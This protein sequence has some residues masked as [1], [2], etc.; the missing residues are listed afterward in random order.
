MDYFCTAAEIDFMKTITPEMI[1]EYYNYDDDIPEGHILIHVG[2]DTYC[3]VSVN[4]FKPGTF[5]EQ[6]SSIEHFEKGIPS[7]MGIIPNRTY[8]IADWDEKSWNFTKTVLL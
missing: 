8:Y 2:V 6:I 5:I 3:L 1:D 7:W 4:D